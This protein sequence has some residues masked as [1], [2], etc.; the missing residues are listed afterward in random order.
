MFVPR[1]GELH[2]FV[3]VLIGQGFLRDFVVC[4]DDVVRRA[5]LVAGV[6]APEMFPSGDR[7][8][9]IDV[10]VVGMVFTVNC[11]DTSGAVDRIV[12]CPRHF[13]ERQVAAVP[14]DEPAVVF[15]R[16]VPRCEVR[17]QNGSF[18]AAQGH[19]GFSDDRHSLTD[20]IP[21]CRKENFAVIGGV[22]D[23]LRQRL[24]LTGQT[25]VPHTVVGYEN[26]FHKNSH[27]CRCASRTN[28]NGSDDK[29]AAF[30]VK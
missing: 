19:A 29:T 15:R 30:P 22:G 26:T 11:S 21:S 25:V 7:K 6:R 3:S 10:H 17:E 8:L 1:S 16:I 12:R 4:F 14:A 9:R 20:K 18:F 27:A 23:H 28:R 2:P 24:I 13:R 5:F